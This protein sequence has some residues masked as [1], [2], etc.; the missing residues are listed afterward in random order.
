[1]EELNA[2]TVFQT[3][4]YLKSKILSDFQPPASAW[5]M[6]SVVLV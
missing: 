4:E 6:V 5:D 3:N 1:M 2:L